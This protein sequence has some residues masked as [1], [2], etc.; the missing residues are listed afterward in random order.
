M[1]TL[2]NKKPQIGVFGGRIPDERLIEVAVEVGR[3][4]ARRGGILFCG[5]M[6]GIMEAVARGASDTG[7]ITVGIL[8]TDDARTANPYIQIPVVTGIGT[9]R[10]SIIARSVDGAIAVDG[11]FGTLTEI[12]YALDFGKPVVGIDTWDIEGVIHA[13][14][15]GEAVSKLWEAG[16]WK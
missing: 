11:R 4:I 13:E 12:A 5:G 10:N 7:G 15:A 2:T 9:A 16:Q 6:G 14:S 3:L 1:N 8:P